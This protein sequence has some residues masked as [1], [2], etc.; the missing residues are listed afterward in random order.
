MQPFNLNAAQRGVRLITRGGLT[1]RF[2]TC[3]TFGL[4]RRCVRVFIDGLGPVI[5]NDSGRF[6]G[7]GEP[8]ALDIFINDGVTNVGSKSVQPI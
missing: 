3:A 2:I 6:H 8:S 1:A 5:L 4:S 7:D